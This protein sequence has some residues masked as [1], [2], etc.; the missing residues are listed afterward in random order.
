[1]PISED[2]KCSVKC[3]T[4]FT[5]RQ[6]LLLSETQLTARSP[7]TLTAVALWAPMPHLVLG[8][9][10]EAQSPSLLLGWKDKMQTLN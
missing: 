6:L 10:K 7:G 9:V 1:M 2:W 8:S 3:L 5:R 4:P